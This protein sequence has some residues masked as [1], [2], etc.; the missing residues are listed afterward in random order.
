MEDGVPMAAAVLTTRQTSGLIYE[1]VLI[2]V[3]EICR[4]T[5]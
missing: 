3:H 2:F 4:L 5:F 1:F